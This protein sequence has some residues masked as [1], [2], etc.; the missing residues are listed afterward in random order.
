MVALNRKYRFDIIDG[1]TTTTMRPLNDR[2]VLAYERDGDKRFFRKVLKTQLRFAGTDYD[3]FKNGLDLG[4]CNNYGLNIYRNDDGAGFD[5]WFEGR[6]YLS[7]C[8][9]DYSRGICELTVETED[10]YTCIDNNLKT[11]INWLDYGVPANAY[12]IVG[13]FET[14][15]CK[16]VETFTDQEQLTTFTPIDC[17]TGGAEAGQYVITNHRQLITSFIMPQ[18]MT[19]TTEWTREVVFS[20]TSP[21]DTFT[22]ISPG[23]WA[24]P[25]AIIPG[26]YRPFAEALIV[27]TDYYYNAKI[28]D[29]GTNTGLDN[30]RRISEVL[31]LVVD[32]FLCDLDVVSD[33]LNINPVATYPT[34]TAYTRALERLQDV[35][36]Y[37]RSDVVKW[38]ADNNATKLEMTFED[39]INALLGPLNGAWTIEVIADVPTLRIEHISYFAGTNQNDFTTSQ[40]LKYHRGRAQ[41]DIDAK[42]DIP[43]YDQFSFGES[44]TDYFKPSQIMYQGC[45]S[46]TDSRENTYTAVSNDLSWLSDK[47]EGRGTDGITFVAT[48]EFEGKNYIFNDHTRVNG[49]LSWRDIL[50]NY[51][52]YERPAPDFAIVTGTY[53]DSYTAE[54]LKKMKKQAPIQ[55]PITSAV[56]DT[57][58]ASLLQKSTIGWGEVESAEFDTLTNALTTSLLFE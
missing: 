16:F 58:N 46:T 20:V 32:T 7:N 55:I 9:F 48:Y 26:E 42:E 24:R 30:G 19:T 4:I 53:S 29:Y 28:L 14:V 56:Q 35:F 25:A 3:F 47:E 50:P 52:V 12:N 2:V 1:P 34:N 44:G 39:F 17:I 43:K 23:K 21:D 57:F 36:Y 11:K 54:S 37:Q 10:V 15:V 45:S 33:F 27:E 13:T 31:P 41:I 5:L 6:I 18:Q 8:R 40:Y 51:W 22:E 38:N 49:A